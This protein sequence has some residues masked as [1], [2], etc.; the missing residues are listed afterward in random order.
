LTQL[1]APAAPPG[2]APRGDGPLQVALY[3]GI[4][5]RHDA[6]SNSLHLKLEALRRLV[7]LGAPIEVTVFTHA[8][9]FMAPEICVVPSVSRLVGSE[10]FWSADVHIFEF[11]MHY[12]LF[13]A[14]F[15]IPEG[16]STLVI[17]HN[18]TPPELVDLPQ[19]RAGCQLALVQ[20]HNLRLA[21]H[22]ACVSEFNLTM[23]RSVGVPDDR[24]SVLHLPP[25]H[26]ARLAPRTFGGADGGARPVRLLFVGRLV[27]AKGIRDLLVM[28][29]RLWAQRPGQFTIDLV[30]SPTFSDPEVF[31]E[32]ERSLAV[33]G[34]AGRLRLHESLSEREMADLFE[35]SDL[36]VNP[37][38]H[39]GYCVPVIEAL[40][41]GCHVVAYD[42]GNLPNV[43]GGL[44]QLVGTGQ[45]GALGDAVANFIDRA[46]AA[47][48]SGNPISVPTVG[49][50]LDE[51][52]W[53]AA[54]REHLADY[55]SAHYEA[56]FLDLFAQL[57][58]DSAKGLS[59]AIET[60]LRRRRQEI[61]ATR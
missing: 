11:G 24:L 35:A 7:A 51:A 3:S 55:T 36:L 17:E 49:G 48:R 30:G 61:G 58:R 19:V 54:V 57:A 1:E 41:A 8:S 46:R 32:V 21:Q 16:R 47:G 25:A 33:H 43:L 2:L 28:A 40:S 15:V 29:E 12:E 37:S 38:Y 18:T 13:D 5:V 52:A 22:V 9:D 60:A 26:A 42:A 45:V 44:G 50:D 4:Y 6:V 10:A 34:A 31:A 23:A 14:I 56:V 20:R 59:P 53:L 39:E 27:R